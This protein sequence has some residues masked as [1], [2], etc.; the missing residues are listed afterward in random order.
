MRLASYFFLGAVP[1]FG[2]VSAT[3]IGKRLNESK[4][5]TTETT[6][7]E[8]ASE[9][10]ESSGILPFLDPSTSRMFGGPVNF[11]SGEEV[12]KVA[13]VVGGS[14]A[15]SSEA[16][17]FAMMIT[18]NESEGV[19]K[20]MGCGG[21]VTSDRHVL[22]AAH[23]FQGRSGTTDAVFINAYDPFTGNPSVPY[24]FS[25]IKSYTVHPN[26]SD[27]TNA[28]DLAI[29]TLESPIIDSESFPPV[30]LLHPQQD[31]VDGLETKIYGFG[32]TLEDDTTPVT[33]LRVASIPF[34]SNS[35]CKQYYPRSL[36]P[37]MIC[38]GFPDRVA[39]ETRRDACMGDSGG[40][41]TIIGDDGLV[42]QIGI[43]SWGEGCGQSRRPGVYSSVQ[44][45]Y[46]WIRST[47][48]NSKNVDQSIALCSAIPK[49]SIALAGR[50]SSGCT[51]R[52][53]SG[54][55]CSYGGQ[56]CSGVCGGVSIFDKRVCQS[57]AVPESSQ[58]NGGQRRLRFHGAV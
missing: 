19:W 21:A 13:R 14:Q 9:F 46:E 54:D 56:C 33:T 45:H 37:D 43:V 5:Q 34:I 49:V 31:L 51:N 57:T 38:G 22:T 27:E 52:K 7:K 42:Y 30:R 17:F 10:A 26:Y 20:N 40:P 58:Q 11:D 23:C 1:L 47:V 15:T 36:F 4:M 25:R 44:Y 29:I 8:G 18:W 50:N 16:P 35:A 32:Q 48:C 55:S 41:M 2:N 39:G 12:D 3:L 6:T 53:Q 28:S 24:H